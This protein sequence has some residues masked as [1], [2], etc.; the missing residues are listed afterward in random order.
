MAD[1]PE[2]VETLAVT[3]FE[4]PVLAARVADGT[5]FMSM[6]DLCAAVGLDARSQVRRLR[7]DEDLRDGLQR[8]RVTTAGGPQEQDFLILEFV[9]AW[10]TGVNRKRATPVVRERLRYLR[11]FSIREVYNAI[12]R[13]A[14]LPE[15]P[16][17][18]IEDLDDLRH[19][20][21]SIEAIAERQAAIETSQERARAAWREHEQRIR[22]L[23]DQLNQPAVLSVTQRG[24]IY[25]L[26]QAWAQARIEHEHVSSA[27]AFVGCWSAIKT[28]YKVAKYEH[29]PARSYDDCVDYIQRAYER[30]TGHPLQLPDGD[31]R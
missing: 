3:F 2:P 27:T 26:V 19:Y 15:G 13:T 14:G 29:I 23:E 17:S 25:Q 5:I 21:M 18:A 1:S 20:D 16:S 4:Q 10:I 9:P 28:R 7:A 24:H 6:R 8:L 22:A 11:L 12:A 31:E 30:M